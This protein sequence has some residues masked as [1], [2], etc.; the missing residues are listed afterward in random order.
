[1][2]E[3][4]L[5]TVKTFQTYLGDKRQEK[6]V[7][8]GTG[9][10][11]EAVVKSCSDYR[12]VGLMD[13]AKTGEDLWGLRVLS[14][15]EILE[16]GVKCIVVVA[17]PAVLTVIYKRIQAWS[18]ENGIFVCDIY[19]NDLADKV[20]K[21]RKS[22]P[23]FE[24]SYEGLL[25]KIDRYEVI[26]FD[27]FD[28]LLTRCVYAPEDV[29]S[30]LD[31]KYEGRLPF[32]F[33]V[34]RR[35]AE[36]ELLEHG[37]T[38]IYQIYHLIGKRYRLSQ[39]ET[40]SLLEAEIEKEKEVLLVREK[41]KECL[42]YCL[43]K[44]K[45]VYLISDMYF[46]KSILEDI[47]ACKGITG[48]DEIIVSC[49]AGCSKQNG[50]YKILKVEMGEHTWLHIGDNHEA[51]YLAVKKA[52][53]DAFEILTPIRMMEISTYD[54]LLTDI[55]NIDTRIMLGLLAAKVFNDPFML[56]HSEGKPG[57][58]CLYD[59]GF[60]FIAPLIASFM[61]WMLSVLK[62]EEDE[63]LIFSARDGWLLQKVY[64]IFREN[65]MKAILPEDVYLLISRKAISIVTEKCGKEERN[66]YLNY[67]KRLE[68]EKYKTIYFFDFMSKGTCQSKFE[69]LIGREMQGIYFQKSLSGD[70]RKD[71]IRAWCF[72]KEQSASERDLRIFAMCDFLECILSSPD[73]SFWKMDCLGRPV[74]EEEQRTEKQIESILEIHDGIL[75]YCETFVKIRG[76]A[77]PGLGL[78]E[79]CDKILR[80][81]E[82]AASRIEIPEL[83]EF[84]LDDV[85]A[86]K[87]NT[88]KDV[89]A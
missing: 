60:L 42:Q 32:L 89:L 63:L 59:F 44:G 53:G 19:G 71:S 65:Y 77:Q 66:N 86:A 73:P 43:T 82:S 40:Q 84:E 57:I 69:D 38:D 51:D 8:Y 7:V 61:L 88:G 24:M 55:K 83:L 22:S 75:L 74:Y 41:M 50:L 28:T 3:E 21:K 70:E 39:K 10:N 58:S 81:T 48:Y 14:E 13:A 15:K 17:R 18:E 33:S 87:K 6:L 4:Q 34:E 37:E 30:L 62:K 16:A 36:K 2:L 45:K 52:G 5:K 72:F 54:V 27:I 49:D 26:S 20:K 35:R 23:Y 80:L 79:F 64:H 78:A 11:A 46:P 67:I 47:L 68:L 56:Y 31:M 9:I 29:F 12:I 1:M 76:K 25:R 85:V